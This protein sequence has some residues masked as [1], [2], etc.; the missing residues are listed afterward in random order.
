[1]MMVNKI[2]RPNRTPTVRGICKFTVYFSV[3]RPFRRFILVGGHFVLCYKEKMEPLDRALAN[4]K[5]S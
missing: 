2:D 5:R 4:F 1:M 3:S